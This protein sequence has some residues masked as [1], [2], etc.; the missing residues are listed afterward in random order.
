[1]TNGLHISMGILFPE[2]ILHSEVFA[3]LATVVAI[4]TVMY[5]ALAVVKV[6]P[7]AHP[8]AWLRTRRERQETRSIYPDAPY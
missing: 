2:S 3:I 4:N 7:K 5:T 1:M 6:L 8:P